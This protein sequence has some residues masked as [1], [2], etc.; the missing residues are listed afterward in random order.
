MPAVPRVAGYTGVHA[1]RLSQR[2]TFFA[3]L[4][5]LQGASPPCKSHRRP[6]L[7]WIERSDHRQVTARETEPSESCATARSRPEALW[8]VGRV[9]IEPTTNGLRVRCSTS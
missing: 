1:P 8:M 4:V 9:G 6:R 7:I 3:T 2:T 5:P